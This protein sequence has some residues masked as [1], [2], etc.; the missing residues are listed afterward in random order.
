MPGKKTLERD[1]LKANG[2]VFKNLI[3]RGRF[4]I[5]IFFINDS[6]FGPQYRLIDQNDTLLLGGQRLVNQIVAEQIAADLVATWWQ[7]QQRE[8]TVKLLLKDKTLDEIIKLHGDGTI[9]TAEFG[10]GILALKEAG[11][12]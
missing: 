5:E 3:H 11:H 7:N 2:W 12:V 6:F 9:T 4:G 10:A 1:K 8:Y